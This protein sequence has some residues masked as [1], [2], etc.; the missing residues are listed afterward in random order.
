MLLASDTR[1]TH[2]AVSKEFSFQ[3][4]V[5]VV[6][7]DRNAFLRTP[8]FSFLGGRLTKIPSGWKPGRHDQSDL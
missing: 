8:K 4:R 6:S 5:A 1:S 2:A 3:K 7:N